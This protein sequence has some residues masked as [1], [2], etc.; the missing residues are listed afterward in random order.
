KDFL[1]ENKCA[2]P[3]NLWYEDYFFYWAYLPLARKILY[4]SECKYVIVER[5]DSIMGQS[6][7]KHPRCMD[8][9]EV[10]KLLFDF[11]TK[12]SFSS[13]LSSLNL[14]NF[15]QCWRFVES[16]LPDDF[17]KIAIEK[18][19]VLGA[20]SIMQTW[21]KW[22]SFFN[23]YSNRRKKFIK[24][25]PGGFYVGFFRFWPLKVGIEHN[26]VVWRLLGF[27]FLKYKIGNL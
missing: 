18:F 26:Y 8:H 1:K 15:I 17:Y 6:N 27:R 25:V 23:D 14:I 3:I 2:F 12:S 13:R 9:I 7:K 24:Y 16:R 11:R 4:L 10:L 20:L 21:C 19:R 22:L 5:Q